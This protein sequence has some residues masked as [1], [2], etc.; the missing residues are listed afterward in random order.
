MQVVVVPLGLLLLVDQASAVVVH[1]VELAQETDLMEQ[2]TP[3][4]VAVVVAGVQHLAA[5][6]V[7]QV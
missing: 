2:S 7:G 6:L 1:L 3:E 4:A 5:V